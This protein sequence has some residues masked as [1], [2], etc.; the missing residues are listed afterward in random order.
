MRLE[1]HRLNGIITACAETL[2]PTV[3]TSGEVA[4]Y[5]HGSRADDSKRGGDI[6]LLLVGSHALLDTLKQKRRALL[7]AMEKH[8]GECRIDLLIAPQQSEE[9]SDF[10]KTILAGAVILHPAG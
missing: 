6:D 1:A 8:I 3:W 10:V 2:G 9:Q 5:L 4:L 7:V